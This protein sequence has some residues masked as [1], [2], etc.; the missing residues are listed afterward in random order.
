MMLLQRLGIM[1]VKQSER[2]MEDVFKDANLMSK[3]F[4]S[5]IET[6]FNANIMDGIG[7]G[8]FDPQ[9]VVTRAQASSVM[10]KML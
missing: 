2:K 9:G 4:V 7:N 3:M 1:N 6:M 10:I 5:D 8:K